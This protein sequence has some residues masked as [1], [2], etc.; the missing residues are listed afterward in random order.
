MTLRERIAYANGRRDE[1]VKNG[2]ET[3]IVFWNGY[4][5]GLEAYSRD[6]AREQERKERTQKEEETNGS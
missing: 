5:A 6:L 1:S 3:D 4:I 2:S